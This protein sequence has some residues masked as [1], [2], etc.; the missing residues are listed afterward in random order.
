MD[1]PSKV[2]PL[3]A[4]AIDD[5]GWIMW[6]NDRSQSATDY[7]KNLLFGHSGIGTDITGA[8]KAYTSSS[9]QTIY[10]GAAAAAFIGIPAGD[11]RLPDVI[12]IAQYGTVYTGGTGKIA[13]HGGNN[14]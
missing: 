1:F 14:P 4:F 12:G 2:Q 3:V 11:P 10:S 5:D 6:T 9:L 7:A 13:E 8:P